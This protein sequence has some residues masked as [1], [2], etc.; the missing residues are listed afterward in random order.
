MGEYMIKIFL[1]FKFLKNIFVFCLYVCLCTTCMQ[2]PWKPEEGGVRFA[3]A[4][5]L[6]MVVSCHVGA[7]TQ[8]L[9]QGHTS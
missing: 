5:E 8:F 6:Q 3:V 7:L 4:L 9:Q 1:K 2:C